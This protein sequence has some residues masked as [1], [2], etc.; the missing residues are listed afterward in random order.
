MSRIVSP[1]LK[2]FKRRVLLAYLW[3]DEEVEAKE[4]EG[5]IDNAVVS[6]DGGQVVTERDGDAGD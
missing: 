5:C 2:S 4:Y 6:I 3:D 1:F